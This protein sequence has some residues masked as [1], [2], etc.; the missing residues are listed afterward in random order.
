MAQAERART[1]VMA[2]WPVAGNAKRSLDHYTEHLALSLEMLA[3]QNLYFISGNNK[4]LSSV[5]NLCR[6]HGI[7]LHTE[8]LLLDD[9]RK[10]PQMDQL[11][12]RARSFGAKL[13]APPADFQRDKG[14]IHYWRDLRQSGEETFRRVFCI[15]H[16]KIDLLQKAARDNPFGSLEF[17]WVDASISR[18]NRQRAGWDFRQVDCT[19]GVIRH[20]P[21]VM[22]KNGRELALNA[23]FL[24]ADRAGID[25]LHAAYEDAFAASLAEN[26]PNDEETVL[27]MVVTRHP[28]LFRA[29]TGD[30]ASQAA[31]PGGPAPAGGA[32]RKLLVVGTFRS[33]TNAMQSCLEAHFDVEVTFNEWFWKHGVPPTGIQSPI[34]PDVP[35]VVMAKSPYA[36]HESLYPFWLHRRPNLDA[37]PDVSAFA[38]KELQV[39]DV[40]GGNLGR[41][42]YWFR[43]PTDYW[44]QFYFSWLSWTEVR[45]RCQFVRYE[46]VEGTP[47]DEITRIGERFGLRRKTTGLI[48]LPAER[49]GPHVPTE[50][51]GERFELK[52]ADRAWIRNMV[53]PLVARSL[54][55]VL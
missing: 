1:Y 5:E 44:N 20:Y 2:Y 40:S 55:Y 21:N 14:L 43:C 42:K 32:R 8:K 47:H 18:F 35:V 17:A 31:G 54:G 26:Y 51:K 11:L 30:A 46:D 37:G 36:F 19:P 4:V 3:G 45:P 27:D 50:R 12:L 33:G 24:L 49:V 34:P 7:R 28:A 10:R 39:F 15:W 41:P 25:A 9:L 48:S 13:P 38:R 22:R 52:E 6:I 16:S 23:S 53:N 29:I